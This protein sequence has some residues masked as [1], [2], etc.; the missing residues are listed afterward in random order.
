M[1]PPRRHVPQRQE[2]VQ[3]VDEVTELLARLRGK[4]KR[5]RVGQAFEPLASY[6][7]FASSDKS[8]RHTT[9][10][11]LFSITKRMISI[12][13]FVLPHCRPVHQDA[14]RRNR[15]SES[16]RRDCWHRPPRYQNDLPSSI[17]RGRRRRIDGHPHREGRA[18]H[19]ATPQQRRRPD[20]RL[21]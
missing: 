19:Q 21:C 15:E 6:G 8:L 16:P 1:R 13:C 12:A 11:W 7:C 5:L 20:P 14:G 2:W 18:H 4:H 10:C 3:R 9:A 17:L